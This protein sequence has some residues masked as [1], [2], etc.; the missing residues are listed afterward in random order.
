MS[1]IVIG[2]GGKEHTAP[3]GMPLGLMPADGLKQTLTHIDNW[4]V[5]S[6]VT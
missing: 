4:V 6:M 5:Y 1:D 2:R 3:E